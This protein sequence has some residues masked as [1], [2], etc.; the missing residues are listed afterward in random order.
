LLIPANS[1]PQTTVHKTSSNNFLIIL[2]L[3][4]TTASAA[5]TTT[6]TT[7]RNFIIHIVRPAIAQLHHA[8]TTPA[9][10]L[11]V[12]NHVAIHFDTNDPNLQLAIAS[13]GDH[14]VDIDMG[15]N[16]DMDMTDNI[17]VDMAENMDAVMGDE[18]VGDIDVDM[19]MEDVEDDIG[20]NMRVDLEDD[21]QAYD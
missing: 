8:L 19:G 20:D 1:R 11:P 2:T 3:T 14:M 7:M 10:A 18:I 4:L 17:D 12:D 16:I 13:V 6:P 15:D 5:T 21:G 9:A